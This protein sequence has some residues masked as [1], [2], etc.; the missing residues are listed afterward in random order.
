MK[1]KSYF[2]K[3][4]TSTENTTIDALYDSIVYQK[5]IHFKEYLIE[6]PKF[7]SFERINYHFIQK[8]AFSLIEGIESFQEKDKQDVLNMCLKI[9]GLNT[10]QKDV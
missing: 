1:F 4:P 9:S 7:S 2:V 3:A 10:F 6:I 8:Y 5:V